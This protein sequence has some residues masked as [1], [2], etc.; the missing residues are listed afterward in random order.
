MYIAV[1]YVILISLR[2]AYSENHKTATN[3][4][5]PNLLKLKRMLVGLVGTIAV[6]TVYISSKIDQDNWCAFF[7][8]KIII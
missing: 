8:G 6:F 7:F 1:C 3:K 2:G 5:K 4:S